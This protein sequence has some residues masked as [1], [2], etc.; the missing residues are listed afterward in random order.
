MTPA[1]KKKIAL[2]FG[3]LVLL[4]AGAVGVFFL[5]RQQLL[6]YALAQVKTRVERKYPAQLTL[7]PAKF[8]DFNT[9]RIEGVSLVPTGRDTLLRARSINA[10]LSARSLFAGRPVF[11]NLQIDNARLTA[12]KTAA[13]DNFSFLYKTKKRRATVAR[14]TTQGTNYGLLLNQLIEAGFDNIPAEADFKNFL[15]TYRSPGHAATIAMPSLTIEDGNIAGQLTATFDSVE[16]RVGIQ[17]RVEP[18]DYAVQAKVYGLDKRPVIFPY[19]QQRYKARVQFDTLRFSLTDK[20]LDD[21]ELTLRGTAA[22]NNFAVYQAKLSDRDIVVRNGGMDFVATLG[23]GAF[24]L[25]DGT[26][27]TLNKMVFYPAISL[28][29]LPVQQRRIGKKLN[30]LTSRKDLLAGLQ[31]SADIKSTETTA[32]DFFASLPEGMFETLEGTKGEGTLTYSLK[33]ALDM[34]K[35]DSLEFNSTLKSKNFRITRWG[36]EDLSKLNRAFAYTAYN[37]KGDS[38]RTFPVGPPNRDFTP[39]NRISNHLKNAIL[40]AE[41]PRFFTHKGFMEKAFV[42]SAIQNIKEKRFAR[43]GSTISMQLVKNVFLTRKK[44]L[45]RKAEETLIVWIIENT[46][47]ASKERMFEVYLNIIE[48]GPKVYGVTDA[49]RF[50]FDKSPSELNLSE[51]LYL[52]SI[53]PKPKFYRYSFDSY[54]NL[55]GSARYFYRLIAGIMAKRG[56][57][58]QSAYDD[59]SLG[60]ALNGPARKYIVTAVDTVRAFAPADSA[61]FEPLNLIDLLGGNTAPDEGVNT[62]PPDQDG[63]GIPNPTP[64]QP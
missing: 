29:K 53:V 9:V 56:M 11:S 31:F 50:Y 26:K 62:T 23:Q 27:V 45:A 3:I 19:L 10:S 59:L 5:K 35:L 43:G 51:S 20:E 2:G 17:G 49:A 6:D 42:K 44:T 24:S 16:N 15:V 13:T 30:G 41:D 1:T 34:N 33:A 18:R 7:G 8:T 52:A 12:L 22:A 61:Q 55:R 21:N 63:D 36:N 4:L 32:N 38:I 37:D 14:D 46:R 39:F 60:V 64:K 48:W 28:R 47:L 25:D 58:S 57:I 40:T 54:G